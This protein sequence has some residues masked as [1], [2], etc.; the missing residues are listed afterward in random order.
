MLSL[1]YIIQ[2]TLIACCEHHCKSFVD[3][4]KKGEKPLKVTTFEICDNLQISVRAVKLL[5]QIGCLILFHMPYQD[6]N[7]EDLI[8]EITHGIYDSKGNFI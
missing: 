2:D 3:I 8:S 4:S 1:C 7:K 5:N 6:S